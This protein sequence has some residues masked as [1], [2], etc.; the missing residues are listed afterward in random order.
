MTCENKKEDKVCGTCKTCI[1]I[2]NG[3]CVDVYEVDAASKRGI[4]DARKIRET[5][6]YAPQELKKKKNEFI[7]RWRKIILRPKGK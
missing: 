7:L 4:D 2:N 3:N 5:A 1:S 6:Y